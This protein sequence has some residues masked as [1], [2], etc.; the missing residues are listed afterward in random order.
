MERG[1]RTI[2]THS[3]D[4]TD[5]NFVGPLRMHFQRSKSTLDSLKGVFNVFWR[6]PSLRAPEKC[7]VKPLF[8]ILYAVEQLLSSLFSR[9]FYLTQLN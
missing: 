7:Y 3:H 4:R 1:V 6:K 5:L 9:Y 2:L 8:Q